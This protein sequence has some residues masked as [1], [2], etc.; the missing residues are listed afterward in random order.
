MS[1]QV[2]VM[3]TLLRKSELPETLQN[4]S[5]DYVRPN[6]IS[7]CNAITTFD[8]V[9]LLSGLKRGKTTNAAAVLLS[10]LNSRRYIVDTQDV[11]LYLSVNQLCYQNRTQDRYQR[12]NEVQTMVKRAVNA[13]CLVL[14][15]LFSYLTQID[16]LMLQ[17]IYDARQNKSC[18]TV[19][20]TP[21]SDPL[22][23]AGSILYR[24]A[25]DAKLKEEF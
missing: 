4:I 20:T 9:I 10:Y 21:I 16:D 7:I 17:A 23:C 3:Q 19:V 6:I 25:R 12:D 11:G 18:I 8:G 22:N 2:D 24:L 15:G 1:N 5:P 14:D 13:K